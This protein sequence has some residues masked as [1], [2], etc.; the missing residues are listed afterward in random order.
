VVVED[1]LDDRPLGDCRDDLEL[2]NAAVRAVLHWQC[3][4]R[5][6]RKPPDQAASNRPLRSACSWPGQVTPSIDFVAT[7]LPAVL[8]PQRLLEQSNRTVE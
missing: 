4:S 8:H 2:P 1:L 7:L 6:Q 5:M 3:N